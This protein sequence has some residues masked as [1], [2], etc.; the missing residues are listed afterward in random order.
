MAPTIWR[1]TALLLVLFGA[2]PVRAQTDPLSPIPGGASAKDVACVQAGDLN[3]G[4]FAGTFLQTGPETWE[5]RPHMKAGGARFEE[6]PRQDF[7]V[8]LVDTV[9]A[10]AIQLDFDRKRIRT[11]PVA[12]PDGWRDAFHMLSASNKEGSA[13]CFALARMSELASQ[14]TPPRREVGSTPGPAVQYVTIKIGTFVSVPPGTKITATSGPPC[15][16]QPGYFLCPNKFS[17]APAGGV[18][19]PGAGSCAPGL[20]CDK[21]VPNACIG[22]GDPA[23]CAG[24]GNPLTGISLHCAPGSI[25]LPGNI[26][27]P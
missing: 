9:R 2:A 22:P 15:P 24:T 18:C 17:C 12:E 4:A 11:T 10:L 26:C 1:L 7:K 19:C 21:F 3:T 8:E 25:C 13:D 5:E 6:K 23:F 20:F 14:A 27:N 16:G